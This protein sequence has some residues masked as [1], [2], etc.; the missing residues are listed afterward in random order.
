M[1]YH[2]A[3]GEEQLG[4]FNDLDVSAGLREGRFKPTDLC[5]TEGMTEWLTLGSHLQELNLE[6]TPPPLPELPGLAALRAEV[7]QDQVHRLELASRG[8]RLA[9]KLIDLLMLI[10]PFVIYYVIV[11]DSALQ[12]EL[13]PLQKDPSA[14]IVVI[15]R[16]IDAIQ[17]SGNLTPI[18]M[19]MIMNLVL[20]TNM[21]LL[22]VRGQT[23]GKMCLG[24]QVVKFPDGT[25]AG[26]VKAVL[27]RNMLFGILILASVI[28][29][30]LVGLAL[31]LAN[32]FMI[33]RQDHRCMHDLM[34]DTLVTKRSR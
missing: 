32:A 18:I 34:A 17:A 20:L 15:Q 8:Q 5:W 4:T 31:A 30:G 11:F 24:I 9:A 28:F 1:K 16:R 14:M 29:F 23:L 10:V 2:L 27:L 19:S 7:R 12:E 6:A 33:F 21:V 22:A 25:R 3:R 13:Q 26:F